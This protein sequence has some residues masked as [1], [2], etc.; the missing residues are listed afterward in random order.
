[1]Y[2]TPFNLIHICEIYYHKNSKIVN[3]FK[4]NRYPLWHSIYIQPV[5]NE[6]S[7]L[8]LQAFYESKIIPIKLNNYN[9]NYKKDSILA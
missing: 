4:K 1:M 5:K 2:N 3:L 6:F 9:Q 8:L 7:I